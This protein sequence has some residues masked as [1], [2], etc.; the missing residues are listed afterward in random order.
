MWLWSRKSTKTVA[1]QRKTR[2]TSWRRILIT[3]QE[4]LLALSPCCSN[5]PPKFNMI[6]LR[7]QVP[8]L[9]SNFE[10]RN[11]KQPSNSFI[12][13]ETE[14]TLGWSDE[15]ITHLLATCA[16]KRRVILLPTTPAGTASES[17]S[18]QQHLRTKSISLVQAHSR[19]NTMENKNWQEKLI[20]EANLLYISEGCIMGLKED[21]TYMW[22][23]VQG[24]LC[25]LH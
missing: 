9:Y 8:Q 14:T 6:F 12:H 22:M 20:A 16:R 2:K 13:L 24:D 4:T 5:L 19:R 3:S 7:S 17:I 25:G 1:N 10:R 23:A 11:S 21:Y 15:H 18:Q